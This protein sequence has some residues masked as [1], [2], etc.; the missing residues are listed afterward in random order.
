MRIATTDKY[1]SAG[2]GNSIKDI[3][4]RNRS[5]HPKSVNFLTERKSLI[6]LR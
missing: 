5:P 6:S 2:K 1:V 4:A 3:L